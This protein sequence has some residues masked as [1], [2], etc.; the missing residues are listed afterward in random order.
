MPGEGGFPAR[1]E[2][3]GGLAEPKGMDRGMVPVLHGAGKVARFE[4][5]Y[6]A[7]PPRTTAVS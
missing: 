1:P 2:P 5:G 7:M 4:P 6:L 3:V